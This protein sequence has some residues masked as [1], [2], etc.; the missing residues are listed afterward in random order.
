MRKS[1]WLGRTAAAASLVCTLACSKREEPPNPQ[2][3]PKHAALVHDA[4]N[5]AEGVANAKSGPIRDGEL[6]ALLVRPEL[7]TWSHEEARRQLARLELGETSPLPGSQQL[8]AQTSTLGI[9]LNYLPD[10]SGAYRF[11]DARVEFPMSDGKSARARYEA[12]SRRL[13]S[14]H[15]APSWRKDDESYPAR[16]YAVDAKLEVMLGAMTKAD[17]AP[18]MVVLS[19]A[20]K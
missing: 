12:L 4:G 18:P 11:A 2:P 6:V 19:L 16:G 3:T 15:G 20:A 8:V 9:T 1:C 7:R 10:E 13:E 14:A 5:A 17:E